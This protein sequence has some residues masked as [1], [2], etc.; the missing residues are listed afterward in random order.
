MRTEFSR[1]QLEDPALAQVNAILRK[2]VRCGFCNTACPTFALSGDELDGPR[3]RIYLLKNLLEGNE[4]PSAKVT[5]HLDRCLSC[6]SCMTAC[7]S[8]VDYMRLIDPGRAYLEKRARRSWADRLFRI[9]LAMFLPHPG[10]LRLVL[11]LAGLAAPARRL[12]PRRLR[13]ALALRPS[14]GPRPPAPLPQARDS[15]AASG[16]AGAPRASASPATTNEEDGTVVGL[17]AGCVQQVLGNHINAA[18]VRLLQRHGCRVRLLSEPACCGA[19]EHHLGKE[20]RARQRL[21]QNTSAWIKQA[22]ELGLEALLVA[23]SGC[24]AMLKDYGHLLRSDDALAADAARLS[25]MTQDI[26]QFLTG[27]APLPANPQLPPL[28]VAYQSPCAM[29]HGQKIDAEPAALL[30]Q[31]GFTVLE[32]EEKHLCCGSAGVYNLLQPAPADALGER[33][34]AHLAQL[35]PQAI[36]SGNLGCMMQLRRFTAVPLLHTVELLDWAAGGPRP[37]S[38]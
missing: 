17:A 22:D 34:A 8:G 21:R 31:A 3:G 2:C 38:L 29:L 7:P 33:K 11:F 13:N 18:A 4:T 15:T 35:K 6:L 12:L 37:F 5:H 16:P 24:G 9:L 28:R 1:Q 30:R 26:A 23:A 25:D 14:R 10:R 27:R 32:P 36:A 20:E 19:V